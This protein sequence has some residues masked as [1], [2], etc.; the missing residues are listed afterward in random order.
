MSK[1]VPRPPPPQPVPYP[2]PKPN[3]GRKI[4]LLPPP[5]VRLGEELRAGI[6]GVRRKP[7]RLPK[8][9]PDLLASATA[10]MT[11]LAAATAMITTG[12]SQENRC[13]KVCRLD[14]IFASLAAARLGWASWSVV[15]SMS[16]CGLW[17]IRFLL[18]GLCNFG[19][20]FQAYP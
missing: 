7:L 2:P 16:S 19:A 9:E 13:R 14:G 10:G 12:T 8:L 1:M 4:K 6:R 3:P 5:R 11:K 15:V 20:S 17:S 18:L